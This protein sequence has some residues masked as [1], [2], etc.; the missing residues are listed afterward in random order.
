M[1]YSFASRQ[2]QSVF[3]E[4]AGAGTD[5]VFIAGGPHPSGA[6]EETLRFFDYVVVGEGEE[7]LP[8]LIETINSGG[9]VA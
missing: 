1:V 7:T 9:D 6:P 3:D 2:K 4:I 8:E 5:S